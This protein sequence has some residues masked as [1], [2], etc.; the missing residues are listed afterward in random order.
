MM[1]VLK[2]VDLF[3]SF[4]LITS[5]GRAA[6]VIEGKC[7]MWSYVAD[8]LSLDGVNMALQVAYGMLVDTYTQ[9]EM[10][11]INLQGFKILAQ[12]EEGESFFVEAT[13]YDTLHP[14]VDRLKR[15]HLL[16]IEHITKG[17]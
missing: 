13:C 11:E 12:P 17:V 8:H 1:K 4:A 10:E 3:D 9:Q 15:I 14:I 2:D 7:I 6:S 16:K 5:D